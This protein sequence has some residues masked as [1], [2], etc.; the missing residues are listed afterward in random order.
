MKSSKLLSLALSVIITTLVVVLGVSAD[1]AGP[2]R[3]PSDGNVDAPINIGGNA[4]SK[5]G[6]LIVGAGLTADRT[7]LLS[8][9]GIWLLGHLLA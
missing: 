1:W 8:P 3:E 5:A 7:A 2:L 9:R 6:G 4:Q